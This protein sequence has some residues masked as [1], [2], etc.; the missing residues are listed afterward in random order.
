[1]HFFY[2]ELLAGASKAEALRSAQRA[3]MQT[4]IREA[5]AYCEEA[6]HYADQPDLIRN[7]TSDI[8]QLQYLAGDFN[9]AA[10]SFDQAAVLLDE[11]ES[12]E[13][14]ELLRNAARSRAR[15]RETDRRSNYERRPYVDPYYWAPFVL[16]GDWR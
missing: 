10:F 13:R 4:S 6:K 12:L 7:I 14:R 11:A 1:M 9:K 15:Q 8:A 2:T 16:V 3:V 5:I